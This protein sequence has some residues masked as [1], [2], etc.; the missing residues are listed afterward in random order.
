M[1]RFFSDWCAAVMRRNGYRPEIVAGRHGLGVN[2]YEIALPANLVRSIL[3]DAGS[4]P[5][6]LP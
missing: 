6:W 3:A 4:P 2:V 5:E 1:T